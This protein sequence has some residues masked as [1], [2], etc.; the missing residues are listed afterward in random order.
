M[1]GCVEVVAGGEGAAGC[2]VDFA[3]GVAAE[4]DGGR[5][6]ETESVVWLASG[7]GTGELNGTVVLLEST[8]GLVVVEVAAVVVELRAKPSSLAATTLS[9]QPTYTPWTVIMGNA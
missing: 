9:A 3:G 5:K 8:V 7:D 2:G 4:L 6:P 1:S